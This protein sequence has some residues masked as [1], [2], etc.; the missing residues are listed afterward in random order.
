M[1]GERRK[2]AAQGKARVV[3]TGGEHDVERRGSELERR[4]ATVMAG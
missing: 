2:E 3:V 1:L 4:E